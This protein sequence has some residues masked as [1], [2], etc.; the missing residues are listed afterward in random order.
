[1][2]ARK[3]MSSKARGEYLELMQERYRQ[4][5]RKERST[6]L[7]EMEGVTGLHR[8]SLIRLMK[9]DDLSRKPRSRERGRTYGLDVQNALG[10]IAESFDYICAERLH[11]NLAW[12]AE[13]LAR[14]G[15]LHLTGQLRKQLGQISTSTIRRLLTRVRKD[16]YHLPRPKPKPANSILQ[17]IPMKRLPWN[18][19]EPGCFEV[20][21]VFHS[22]SD[23]RGEFASSLHMVDV[24]TGWS[25]LAAILGRSHLVVGDAFQRILGRLPF[26]ILK[27]HP[28][29]G[30]EFFNHYLMRFWREA[31]PGLV[32][33]RS[34]PYH[35]ND[36]RFVEQKNSSI[37]RSYLGYQ[38]LDTVEQVKAMNRLYD[39]L[40]LY[41]NLFQPVLRMS[42]KEMIPQE[43]GSYLVRHR[44][45]Q[46]RTPFDRLCGTE[47]I[48]HE[49]KE[50]F[51]QLRAQTNPRRLRV[52]IRELADAIL[53]MPNAAKSAEAQNVYLTLFG[54]HAAGA[55]APVTLSFDRMGPLR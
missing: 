54:P 34:R 36:N 47:A 16:E 27:L 1:M 23:A 42:C 12:M 25:E 32:W 8:K 4:A 15:E 20:D 10:I 53:R 26:P 33:S 9:R 17:G 51:T 29:N 43:D 41:Y 46:A 19:T 50:A 39:K 14:H 11:G 2:P 48:S 40:R 6:L 3:R 21:L 24:A 22:G 28:D 37:V 35:K 44:Y 30:S 18:E 49:E 55:T 52:E 5:S 13:Q 45:G 38:R 31:V 7:H